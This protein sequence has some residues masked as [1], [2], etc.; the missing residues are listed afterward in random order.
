MKRTLLTIIS[1]LIIT[2]CNQQNI[3]NDMK[4]EKTMENKN[5]QLVNQYFQHF[6]DHNWSEMANM[7][8]P[9]P[10]FKDPTLGKDIIT[11]SRDEITAK[12]SELNSIFLDIHDEIINIYPSG[13][14]FVIVEFVSTGTDG[15]GNKFELPICTIFE[16][17]NGKITKDFTYFD[18]FE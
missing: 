18:N 4:E 2:A 9:N 15:D 1:L 17:K 6:N 11:L 3:G 16:I 8:I 10:Q 7:Y 5:I 14:K 12:Y 13:E